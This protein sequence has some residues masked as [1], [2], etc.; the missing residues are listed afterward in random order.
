MKRIKFLTFTII[1]IMLLICSTIFSTYA[2]SQ[3]D[4]N[5]VMQQINETE[6]E[7][8]AVEASMSEVMKEIQS[9]EGEIA[10]VQFNLQTL[11]ENLN[12][13]KKDISILQTN[14]EK[15]IKEYEERR[16]TARSRMVAQYKYGNTT[17]LDVLLHSSSL[18]DFLSNYYLVEQMLNVDEGFLDELEEERKQI[19]NDKIELEEKQKQV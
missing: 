13:L 18:T 10:E 15:A 14:L 19:E 5:K 4:A 16:E 9:L 8:Q 12:K 7:R 2:V 11:E 17:F 1:C 3:E 6:K